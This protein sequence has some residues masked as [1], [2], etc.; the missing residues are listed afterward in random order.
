MTRKLIKPNLNEIKKYSKKN[1]GGS[2]KKT[3]PAYR[4][5]AENYYYVKQMNARTSMIIELVNGEKFIGTIDWYDEKCLKVKRDD[6]MNYLL[7]KHM[8]KYMYKNPD[9]TEGDGEGEE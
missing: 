2:K 6:G 9:W 1:E 5:H 4:T 8:I 7:F 3:P